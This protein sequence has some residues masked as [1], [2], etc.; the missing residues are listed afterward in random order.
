MRLY[1]N[2]C[3]KNLEKRLKENLSDEEYEIFENDPLEGNLIRLKGT[4]K[5]PEVGDVF[6]LSFF[7]GKYLYGKV[8][9]TLNECDV[10]CQVVAIF[11]EESLDKDIKNFHPDYNNLIISPDIVFTGYWTKGL[12]QT[13][14]NIPLTEEEKNL[15]YGFFDLDNIDEGYGVFRNAKGEEIDHIPK[16]IAVAGIETIFGIYIEI[17]TEYY[18]EHKIPLP[19]KK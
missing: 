5:H 3:A 18:I 6:V 14:G 7:E 2:I 8:L 12:F 9:E 13:I 17:R 10:E 15:D 4:R 1:Y 19:N 11:K 16:Y